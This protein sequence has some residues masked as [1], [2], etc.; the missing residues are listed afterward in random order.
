MA[1]SSVERQS[2]NSNMFNNFSKI[3]FNVHP[4]VFIIKSYIQDRF[5]YGLKKSR[6]NK[7]AALAS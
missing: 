2:M 4:R 6:T 7:K 3:E 5:K 1:V